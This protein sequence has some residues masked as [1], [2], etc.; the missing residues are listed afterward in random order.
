M[1]FVTLANACVLRVLSLEK[2]FDHGAPEAHGRPFRLLQ[3]MIP[4]FLFN[5]E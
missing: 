1:Q 2:P 3:C 4:A 5:N